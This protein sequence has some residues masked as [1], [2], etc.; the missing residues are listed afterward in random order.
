MVY[1]SNN[2][3]MIKIES[4]TLG[5]V[6]LISGTAIGAGMLGLPI[7]T[8]AAGLSASI[9]LLIGIFLFMLCT[10]FLFLET[11]Y[12]CPDPQTNLIGVCRQLSGGIAESIAWMLF[13]S[14]MYIASASYIIGSGEIISGSIAGLQDQT[15]PC[16]IIFATFF[17]GIAFF[18]MQ[19]VDRLNRVLVA[20]LILTFIALMIYSAPNIKLSNLPGGH[21]I[22]A[23][24]AI[25]TVLTAFTSHIILP[26]MRSYLD[27]SLPKM[28]KAILMGC[29]IP[30]I[31]YIIWEFIIL[32]LLPYEG[33]FSL[34]SILNSN[35]DQLKLMIN[36][37]DV[38][39]QLNQFSE[40]VALF[41]FL[42][43]STSF[44]GV[45]ISLRDFIDD[46][47]NLHQYTYHK[48]YAISLA[49]MPPI[50]LVIFFPSGFS[51]FLHFAGVIILLLYA[52][53]PLYLVYRARY[54]LNLKSEYTLPG[55]KIVLKLLFILSM[56]ILY[57]TWTM[58]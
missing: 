4:K 22:L 14:L 56:M 10:L 32:G 45:M 40:L 7:S 12:F 15:I 20:G 58:L 2:M 13:L 18:K 43:I 37:L 54:Y 19:W 11:I 16:S 9:G 49:F 31:F 23:F 36:F 28:K 17:S 38:H 8:G 24:S 46:G 48:L 57:S 25:P 52:F 47:L 21:P 27:N 42:A 3:T 55:G 51:T 44:W 34:L 1:Y 50:M 35:Q 26:S 41:S 33:E 30:L 39:Y 53:L 5:A 6:F 29:G